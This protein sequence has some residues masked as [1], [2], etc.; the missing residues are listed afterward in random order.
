MLTIKGKSNGDDSFDWKSNLIDVACN[1]K[2]A[3]CGG[4]IA[5]NF[6]MFEDPHVVSKAVC[7]IK[8]LT[9][10]VLGGLCLELQS[11]E[12]FKKL[13]SGAKTGLREVI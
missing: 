3:C 9:V 1:F 6:D 8:Q 7:E 2:K 12:T 13:Y 4:C 10:E 5:M 11:N